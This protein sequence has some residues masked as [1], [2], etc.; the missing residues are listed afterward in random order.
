MRILQ[1]LHVCCLFQSSRRFTDRFFYFFTVGNDRYHQ[2]V[3][4]DIVTVTPT[5]Q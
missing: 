4:V 1:H 2:L 3:G 5:A